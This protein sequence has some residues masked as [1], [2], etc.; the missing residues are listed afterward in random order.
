MKLRVLVFI[1]AL[2]V[3]IT[4][5]VVN[6]YFQHSIKDLLITFGV[7]LATSFMVFYYLIEK[8]IYSKI[9]LIYKLIHNLKLGRDLRDALGEHVSSDPINDVEQ[10]VKE[11]AKQ[12]TTEIDGLRDRKSTRLNSSHSDRSRMPSSA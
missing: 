5:S 11:W 4:L 8:Y 6:Y 9:K 7:T 12:K 10:E 3:A 1:N 2:A